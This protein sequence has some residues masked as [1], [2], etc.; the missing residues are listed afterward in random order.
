MD[1]CPCCKEAIRRGA[2]DTPLA[3]APGRGRVVQVQ[4]RRG[5]GAVCV[6]YLGE[7]KRV[8][9]QTARRDPRASVFAAVAALGG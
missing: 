4:H 1:I 2:I 9:R 5:S 3:V 8:A 6:V 7:R